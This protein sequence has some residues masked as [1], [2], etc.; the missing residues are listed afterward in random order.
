MTKIDG[1]TG[2][3]REET[4]PYTLPIVVRLERA[5]TLHERDVFEATVN[6][7]AGLVL[8]QTPEYKNHDW[9][10]SV[11]NWLNGKFR[12]IVKRARAAEWDKV[13]QLPH[14]FASSYEGAQVAVFEPTPITEMHPL[15]KR[16]Q[17]NGVEFPESP[18][19]TKHLPGIAVAI[20][21]S[22]KMSTGKKTAQVAHAAQLLMMESS[23]EQVL[24]WL[25]NGSVFNYCEWGSFEPQARIVD[26][27][28]T[29]IP[30][31]SNT[32]VSAWV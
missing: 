22:L 21:P 6:T 12:K 5:N 23:T 9:D 4:I 16:L 29:E 20:N 26:A 14:I 7:M 8:N 19:D 10:E 27:G 17:V 13:L 15:L 1:E 24:Q 30:P 25:Q 32:T 28:L 31:G 11:N 2:Y 3:L 18:T